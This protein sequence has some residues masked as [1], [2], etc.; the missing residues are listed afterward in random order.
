MPLSHI[1]AAHKDLLCC[2]CIPHQSRALSSILCPQESAGQQTHLIFQAQKSSSDTTPFLYS[3]A[4]ADSKM[5]PLFHSPAHTHIRRADTTTH[6]TDF[7]PTV[8][9]R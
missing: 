2:L 8:Y 4:A 7:E 3:D 5:A 6:H 9:L 1:H